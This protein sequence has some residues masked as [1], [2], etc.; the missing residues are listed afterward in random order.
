MLLLKSAGELTIRRF[1]DI[2]LD[3]V[4]DLIPDQISCP[5]CGCAVDLDYR[6]VQKQRFAWEASQHLVYVDLPIL[7]FRCITCGTKGTEMVTTD[8]TIGK[9]DL[10]FHYLFELIRR[11]NS[12][13]TDLIHREVLLYERM[14]Q[15]SLTRWQRRFH[16]DF[17]ELRKKNGNISM[18]MILGEEILFEEMFRKFHQQTGRFFLHDDK[19]RI[20]VVQDV[21]SGRK[22]IPSFQNVA[23]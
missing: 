19:A 10:S 21:Q 8:L 14:S 13:D 6:A 22:T 1:P 3:S 11:K 2:I 7:S 15:D 20:V 23:L 17:N 9:S 16:R 4:Y 18:D 12:P 5:Y